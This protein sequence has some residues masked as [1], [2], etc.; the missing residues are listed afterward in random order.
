MSKQ[1]ATIPY[2][3]AEGMI[4]RQSATIKKLWIMCILLV[5][6]LVGTNAMWIWYESQFEYYET[7][8][9]VTQESE[10][11]TNYFVG[12]DYNGTANSENDD[13]RQTQKNRRHIWLSHLPP[14][15]R[16]GPSKEC[17]PRSQKMIPEH[18][19]RS[20]IEQLISEWIIG[21]NASRDREIIRRRLFDGITFELLAA[22]FD[23]SVRQTKNIVYTCERK[24]F[25]HCSK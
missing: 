19:S 18:L 14:L 22:E 13:E 8:Q 5:I 1:S 20:D 6:L 3:V 12:G 9:E 17:W 2:Y 11:G 15:S 7:T 4:D 10:S 21:K 25:S 16:N 24:I 23:L